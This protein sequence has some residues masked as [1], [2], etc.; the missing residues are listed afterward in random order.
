MGAGAARARILVGVG[1]PV[2]I[3]DAVTKRLAVAHLQPP[4]SP[5]PVIGDAVRLTLAYNREGVMGLPVGPYGRWA[6]MAVTVV[7]LAVLARLLRDTGP[8]QRLRAVAIALIMGGAA[9]NLVD[10]LASGRGVVD[11]IDLGTPAW[12]FWTFNVADVAVDVGVA[13]LAWA[14]WRAAERETPRPG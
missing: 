14:L 3:A 5:H 8:R 2:L 13:L 9:G 1:L 10:R 7:I 6:L 11:F 12:R 4:L